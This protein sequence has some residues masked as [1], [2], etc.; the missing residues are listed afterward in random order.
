MTIIAPDPIASGQIA[1][2]QFAPGLPHPDHD[3]Q[4]YVGVP[5][6]RAAA[7]AVDVVAIAVLATAATVVSGI[8]T[9][10]AAFLL[11]GPA[12][13]TLAFL[14]RAM[15][16]GRWSATPGMALLGIELRRFDGARF[17]ALEA[18]VHTAL[19]FLAFLT[20]VPQIISVAMM[21]FGPRGRGLHDL[22]IGAVAI[23][24]PA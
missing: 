19:F 11:A 17:G 9:L 16:L 23:N 14:Y 22:P 8:A 12:T 6:R 7:F 15:S 21:A 13:L 18:T 2:G 4:F 24:R 20:V 1:P 3:A 5:A 10:G